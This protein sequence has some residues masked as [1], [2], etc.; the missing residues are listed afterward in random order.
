MCL[1]LLLPLW[2][3]RTL[4]PFISHPSVLFSATAESCFNS[5]QAKEVAAQKLR[6]GSDVDGEDAFIR[7]NEAS[8]RK[9]KLEV[10]T[11]RPSKSGSLRAVVHKFYLLFPYV[12][13]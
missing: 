12:E 4:L 1:S 2:T 5:E 3:L 13:G 10:E 7:G 6:Q 8:F 11:Q 9:V